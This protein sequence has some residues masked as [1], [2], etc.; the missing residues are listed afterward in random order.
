MSYECYTDDHRSAM[1]YDGL[2]MAVFSVGIPLLFAVVLFRRRKELREPRPDGW[3]TPNK[4]C[5]Y[6]ESKTNT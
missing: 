4:V 2:M 3:R 5:S 6:V 1:V